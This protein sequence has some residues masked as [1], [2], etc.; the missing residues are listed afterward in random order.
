[1]HI[2][3]REQKKRIVAK[4]VLNFIEQVLIPAVPRG[5]PLE[6]VL[7]TFCLLAYTGSDRRHFRTGSDA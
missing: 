7:A 6:Q 3:V 4:C 2:R 1:M 5:C